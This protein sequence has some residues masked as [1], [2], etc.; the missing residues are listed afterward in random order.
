MMYVPEISKYELLLPGM[1]LKILLKD[2][3]EFTAAKI[4]RME[5]KILTSVR[6]SI[7][8]CGEHE[9]Y[10]QENDKH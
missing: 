4:L 1:I 10:L 7:L 9:E 8:S 5:Q 2:S 6:Q 3:I